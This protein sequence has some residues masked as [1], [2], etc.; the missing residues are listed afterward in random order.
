MDLQRHRQC[1]LFCSEMVLMSHPA[2]NATPADVAMPVEAVAHAL[3]Y[4]RAS[5]QV[6]PTA[7]FAH[8]LSQPEEAYAVQALVAQRMGWQGEAPAR[9]WKSGGA[10]RDSV[11]THAALPPE[12]VWASPARAGDWPLHLHGVEA[13]IA[14]RLA[15]DVTP[16]M[17]ASADQA[18]AQSWVE[19]MTVAIELISTHWSDGYDTP[20]LLKLAD[21]QVHGALVLSE[22]QPW[23]D[24]DWGALG[25]TIEVDAVV[26]DTRVGT[27]PLGHP[28][29]GLSAFLQHATRHG[30]TLGKGCVVT[31]GSWNG[32]Y[33]ARAGDHVAVRFDGLGEASV[34]L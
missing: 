34:Q 15:C 20:P 9:Y 5:G 22:W 14:L 29:W 13:E 31:T 16:A 7:P 25:L 23:Q 4:A 8:V 33:R 32:V 24:L 10:S 3:L 28:T 21:F 30:Q 27:H 12:G 18:T 26:V 1:G 6:A 11:I 19:S 17:A 2:S